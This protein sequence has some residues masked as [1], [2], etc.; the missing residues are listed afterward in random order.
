MTDYWKHWLNMGRRTKS[1]PKIF[2]VNWFRKNS[3]GD[4]LWPGFGENLRVLEWILERTRGEG[5][6]VETPIGY[7]PTP[8]AFDMTG[9]NLSKETME[10]LLRVDK[11][12]WKQEADSIEG[13]FSTLGERVPWEIRNELEALRRR[14]G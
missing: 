12:E 2:H 3:K 8:G 5:T 10:E 11:E 1:P 7:V 13:F 4:L 14:L 9:L 6:A